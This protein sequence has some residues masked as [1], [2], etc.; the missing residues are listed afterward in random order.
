MKTKNCLILILA[1]CLVLSVAFVS[2][3]LFSEAKAQ[4]TDNQT[5]SSDLPKDSVEMF[6]AVEEIEGNRFLINTDNGGPLYTTVT[7]DT[8]IFKGSKTATVTD[9]KV[10][11]KLL[12]AHNGIVLKSYP[13]QINIVYRVTIL[14]AD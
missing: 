1:L 9:I 7:D 14:E 13:G 12:I 3:N 10:G 4:K 2:N 11:S 5:E 8:E 6:G